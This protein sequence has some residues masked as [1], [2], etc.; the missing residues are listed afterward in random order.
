MA[1]DGI[2]SVPQTG[3]WLLEKGER[4]MTAQTSAKLDSKLNDMG[5]GAIVNIYNAPAGTTTQQRT[6]DAGQV[7]I[8]VILADINS[9][10]PIISGI[11][12]ATGTTRRGR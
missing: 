4:V 9:G 2:D 10:G 11:T 7:I 3:T 1:H 6:D 5:G 8:D 12:G